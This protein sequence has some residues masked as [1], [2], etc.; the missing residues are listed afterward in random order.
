[1]AITAGSDGRPARISAVEALATFDWT[2]DVIV[3][4]LCTAADSGT[5]AGAGLRKWSS[6]SMNCA[7]FWYSYGELS[8]TM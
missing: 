6:V 5:R 1:M 8:Q 7:S 2:D 4:V 3:E